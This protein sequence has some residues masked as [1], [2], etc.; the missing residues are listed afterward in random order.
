M[1]TDMDWLKKVLEHPEPPGYRLKQSRPK[2]K[3]G[4]YLEV[5]GEIIEV[6]QFYK[7]HMP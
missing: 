5:I 2:P 7:T 6:V 4:P 1:Y 3:I